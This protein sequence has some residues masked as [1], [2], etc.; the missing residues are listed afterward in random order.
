MKKIPI[1]DRVS[2]VYELLPKR[3]RDLILNIILSKAIDNG[4]L[5]KE[6][7]PLLK[8]S[9]FE[10]LSKKIKSLS[11]EN[12]SIEKK[13]TPKNIVKREKEPVLQEVKDVKKEPKN[14]NDF[15]Y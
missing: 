13:T 3:Y 1:F 9:D 12:V 8:K 6:I 10:I 2:E 11:D 4:T 15:I 7:K 5:L 14:V